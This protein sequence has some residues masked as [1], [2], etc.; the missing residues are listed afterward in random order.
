MNNQTLYVALFAIASLCIGSGSV[1]GQQ[2]E[3][4]D[5]Y[6]ASIRS[7]LPYWIKQGPVQVV[8][9]YNNGGGETFQLK[10]EL[11][12]K[13]E[14]DRIDVCSA[15]EG[16]DYRFTVTE[17]G[18]RAADNLTLQ[19]DEL[20]PFRMADSSGLL[21]HVTDTTAVR[22]FSVVTSLPV[23]VDTLGSAPKRQLKPAEEVKVFSAIYPDTPFEEKSFKGA[24]W[25]VADREKDS[26]LYRLRPRA[27]T[28][29]SFQ[30]SPLAQE[31][32]AARNQTFEW[33]NTDRRIV[34]LPELTEILDML[35][36]H[37]IALERG[38]AVQGKNGAFILDT[39]TVKREEIVRESARFAFPGGIGELAT[40]VGID[41]LEPIKQKDAIT[42][43]NGMTIGIVGAYGRDKGNDRFLTLTGQNWRLSISFPKVNADSDALEK[44]VVAE[45]IAFVSK[46]YTQPSDEAK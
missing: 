42:D 13:A 20:P 17:K 37:D 15:K 31:R 8:A 9:S 33:T 29:C 27:G 10:M 18:I 32:W 11:L 14:K 24:H 38:I 28:V 19:I 44:R 40:T 43:K 6:A 12:I 2:G 23:V 5:E 45:L 34:P 21:C 1:V 39:S 16:F 35:K 7:V 3:V 46:K 25:L 4:A 41:G 26:T 36:P 22:I 30:L